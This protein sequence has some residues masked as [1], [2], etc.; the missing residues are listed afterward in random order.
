[1]TTLT[2]TEIASFGDDIQ[3]L[4]DNNV[5]HPAV[6]D[7]F[8]FRLNMPYP[9]PLPAEIA[10]FGD[11][12]QRLVDNSVLTEPMASGKDV[13]FELNMFVPE[14]DTDNVTDIMMEA[15][16][17]RQLKDKRI[18]NIIAWLSK[19]DEPEVTVTFT[20]DIDDDDEDAKTVTDDH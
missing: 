19:P 5:L 6:G 12:I 2:P 18:D 3:R 10:K 17:D 1:M 4:V 15:W 13:V 20:D 8:Y 7:R 11:E 14:H 9:T 16:I